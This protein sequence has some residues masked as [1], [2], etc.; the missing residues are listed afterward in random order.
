MAISQLLW[1]ISVGRIGIGAASMHMNAVPFYVMLIVFA[2]GGAWNWA[3]TARG[4]HRRRWASLIAQGLIRLRRKDAM[5]TPVAIPDRSRL[6]PEPLPVL[7]TRPRRRAR[8]SAGQDY[9]LVCTGNAA[10][11][12]AIF[13]D[14]RFGREARSNRAAASRRTSPRSTRSKR[15]RCWS[16][17]RPATPACAASCCAPSPR[18]GSPRLAPEIAALAHRTDRRLPAGRVRPSA[19]TSPSPCPSASSPGCWACPKTMAADLLRWSNAM[20]GMYHGRPHPRD[21]RPRRC[22]DRGFRRLPARLRRRAP[23]TAPPTT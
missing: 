23:R 5:Q 12:N 19:G 20:V 13:R 18:A 9:D 4:R 6:R 15:I 2:L 10:A 14:R 11:V 7:R 22:R 17:S 16:W 21:G 8:S 3:Q 1:I